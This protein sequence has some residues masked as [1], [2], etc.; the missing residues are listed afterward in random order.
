MIIVPSN[1][2]TV[3]RDVYSVEYKERYDFIFGEE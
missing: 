1:H 2:T 3:I